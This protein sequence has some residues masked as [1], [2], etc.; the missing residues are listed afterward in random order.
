MKRLIFFFFIKDCMSEKEGAPSIFLREATGLVR[1]LDALDV[2]IIVFSAINLGGIL[3]SGIF[4]APYLFPGSNMVA[5]WFIGLLPAVGYLLVYLTLGLLMPRSGGD[6]VFVSRVLGPAFGFVW[7]WIALLYQ[8]TG[9]GGF[10]FSLS[11]SGLSTTLAVLGVIFKSNTF[12]ELSKTVS[13][14]PVGPILSTGFIILAFLITVFGT[15]VYRKTMKILFIV[16]T[17]GLLICLGSLLVSNNSIFSS[18]LKA[19]LPEG[20]DYSTIIKLAKQ[21]GYSPVGDVFVQNL[22]AG[23]AIAWVSYTGF[24]NMVYVGGEVRNFRKTLPTIMLFSLFGTALF[25][26]F[27]SFLAQNTFGYDFIGAF[28]YLYFNAPSYYPLSIPPTGLFL[29][30]SIVQNP[31]F[32]LFVSIS[33][34]IWNF[35]FLP[36]YFLIYS[37]AFFAVAFDRLF[38]SKLAEVNERFN[39][40]INALIVTA[41]VIEV[42]NLAYWVWGPMAAMVNFSIAFPIAFALTGLSAVLLPFLKKSY[43]DQLPSSLKTKILG[44]PL[45]SIAGAWMM[46]FSLILA[47]AAAFSLPGAFYGIG[48]A[49]IL[50]ISAYTSGFLIY[51]FIKWYRAREGIDITLAFKEIPPE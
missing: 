44:I 31:I 1:D 41:L 9:I 27:T 38:P 2:L 34:M 47:S 48:I 8:T 32:V 17:L 45:V 6:Y 24:W 5:I 13:T 10:A 36:I 43:F 37:R 18:N 21:N 7:V 3:T 39:S 15:R 4:E 51:Y 46:V 12:L 49:V 11:W 30:V 26:A 25:S 33:L 16:S 23:L 14:I 50:T 40:P 35:M 42:Y 19:Y 28:Q 20:V 29:L 22:M